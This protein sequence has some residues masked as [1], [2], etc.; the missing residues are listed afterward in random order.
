MRFFTDQGDG[1]LAFAPQRKIESHAAK[2]RN[3][4]VDYFRRQ[5]RELKYGDGLAVDGY[6]E[7][8]PEDLRH[9]V[10]DSKR[11]E[12][13]R[14]TRIQAYGFEARFDVAIGREV[15]LVL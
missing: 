13:E 1:H 2:H 8:A 10:I 5:S 12:H 9:T 15:S 11:P 7:D 14:V 4:H 6:A 3:Y